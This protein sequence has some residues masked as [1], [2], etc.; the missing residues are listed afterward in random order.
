LQGNI[1][2]VGYSTRRLGGLVLR[3]GK[4]GLAT[5]PIPA[6]RDPGYFRGISVC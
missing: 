5:W 1:H 3:D 6:D 2:R 4:A